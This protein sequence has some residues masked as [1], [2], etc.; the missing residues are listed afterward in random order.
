MHVAYHATIILDEVPTRTPLWRC[1]ASPTAGK[2]PS[3]DQI[4]MFQEAAET[5]AAK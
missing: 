5:D 2:P 1:I 4:P 3:P